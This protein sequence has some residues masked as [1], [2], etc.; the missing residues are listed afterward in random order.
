MR[1][2]VL[3]IS[4]SQRLAWLVTHSRM[5]A[6][7]S[8]S[9]RRVLQTSSRSRQ[10]LLLLLLLVVHPA[11]GNA[12]PAAQQKKQ[13]RGASRQQQ[14]VVMPWKV[15][16]GAHSG[17]PQRLLLLLRRLLAVLSH[18]CPCAAVK[19]PSQ[20]PVLAGPPTPKRRQQQRPKPARQHRHSNAA[21][22][23][24]LPLL[25][26]LLLVLGVHQWSSS[27]VGRCRLQSCPSTW[28]RSLQAQRQL[29]PMMRSRQ[30]LLHLLPNQQQ[31]QLPNLRQVDR[32]TCGLLPL[33]Q[34]PTQLKKQQLMRQHASPGASL[35]LQ[36]LQRRD[37]TR[38]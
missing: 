16:P 30:L 20:G 9:S 17:H 32:R 34:Q 21:S 7:G 26:L 11:T 6:A 15:L 33:A 3:A 22:G 25:L 18:A 38:R 19:K 10:P 13:Q 28:N 36:Q 31:Q 35:L 1:R 4:G 14:Q 12:R 37:G 23:S 24:G 2:V 8:S 29:L 5:R 27:A